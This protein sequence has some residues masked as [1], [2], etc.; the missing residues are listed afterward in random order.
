MELPVLIVAGIRTSHLTSASDLPMPLQLS[1]HFAFAMRLLFQPSKL[2]Y[3]LVLE[4]D[5]RQA[6]Q[7]EDVLNTQ[8]L[9]FNCCLATL[10]KLFRINVNWLAAS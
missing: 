7:K 2:S 5:T 10:F 3:N 1:C 4:I 9:D 6:C 8:Y